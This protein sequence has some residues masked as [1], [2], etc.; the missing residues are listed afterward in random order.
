[1]SEVQFPQVTVC[2]PEG[3]NTALNYD[4]NKAQD[5]I[6]DDA[7]RNELTLLAFE[8]MHQHD[9]EKFKNLVSGMI[10][11]EQ[12]SLLYSG[13]RK[14]TL[15]QYYSMAEWSIET[16]GGQGLCSS[17]AF[18]EVRN[19]DNFIQALSVYLEVSLPDMMDTVLMINVTMDTKETKS[20]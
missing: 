20:Q 8:L 14:M 13:Y 9:H 5:T 16:S 6:L 11:D 4:L 3:S 7:T 17:P 2:P 10:D 15:L 18:G 1:M 19:S 12:L